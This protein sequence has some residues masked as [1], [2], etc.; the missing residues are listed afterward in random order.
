MRFQIAPTHRFL[1]LLTILALLLSAGILVSPSYAL[2]STR[3]IVDQPDDFSGFQIHLVYVVPKG[4]ADLKWDINGKINSQLDDAQTF[5]KQKIDRKLLFDTYQGRYDITFMQSKYT[6][7][8][9]TIADGQ[10]ET[11]T[12]TMNSLIKMI[13][14][15]YAETLPPQANPK[16]VYFQFSLDLSKDICGFSGTPSSRAMGFGGEVCTNPSWEDVFLKTYGI[17]SLSKTLVHELTHSFGVAHT[18]VDK[19][20]LMIGNPQCPYSRTTQ[21]VTIDSSGANYYGGN[22]SGIDISQIPV[23]QGGLGNSA[24]AVLIESSTV[25]PSV[26]RNGKFQAYYAIPGQVSPPIGWNWYQAK[27]SRPSEMQISPDQLMPWDSLICTAKYGKVSISGLSKAGKCTFDVPATWRIGDSITVSATLKV[28]PFSGSTTEELLLV[29]P[30]LSSNACTQSFCFEDKATTLYANCFPPGGGAGS[31]QE[32]RK[33]AWQDL[34]TA[35]LTS[36]SERCT[37]DGFSDLQSAVIKN[38][39][40]GIHI[41]RWRV[42]PSKKVGEFTGDPFLF[43]IIPANGAEPTAVDVLSQ[44]SNKQALINIIDDYASIQTQNNVVQ[45]LAT[46][47][48]SS[49]SRINGLQVS[50][51]NIFTS[52][53]NVY[54]SSKKANRANQIATKVTLK[55]INES[56]LSIVS[57]LNGEIATIQ[58]TQSDINSARN[59]AIALRN[60]IATKIKAN[61]SPLTSG[62]SQKVDV[63]LATVNTSWSA[64]SSK[65]AA[66]VAVSKKVG[67]NVASF[68]TFINTLAK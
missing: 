37:Q 60:Q 22:G 63:L 47:I 43:Q 29:R 44:S 65:S 38:Q 28:G 48:A 50:A 35:T 66:A 7:D 42:P 14:K 55:G 12:V 26:T 52:A 10:S 64:A 57:I 21:K 20:D 61:P 27:T 19:T 9:L 11:S 1:R 33:G 3:A 59:A 8:E 58:K 17:N 46:S 23:W 31:L 49:A 30:D 18:C 6:L 13:S 62:L 41:L 51:K 5:L 53:Q 32:F 15:E 67:A 39:D 54:N 56:Y 45:K 40:V 16:T 68:N 2:D 24:N 25:A 36:N 4:Q 34:V